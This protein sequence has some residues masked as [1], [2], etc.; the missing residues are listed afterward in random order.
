MQMFKRLFYF[1]LTN[2]LVVTTI[3]IILA[4]VTHFTGFQ[5]N[6]GG[7][8][9]LLALCFV[10]GFGG[11]FISLA[12]SKFMAKKFYGVQIIDPNTTNTMERNLITKV[13]DF[14]RRANLPKMPEVGYYESAEPNAFATGRSKSSSLVAVSTGLLSS[15]TEDEV[16]GVLAHEIAHI[17]NGDMV[18]LTLIQGVVN[19][20]AMFIS[21]IITQAIMNALRKN[22]DNGRGVGCG[23][24]LLRQMIY[25]FVSI[26]F[27]LLG[28]IV[29]NYFSRQREFRADAGSAKYSS[30]EKMT[31]ALQ[32][33]QKFA[34]IPPSRESGRDPEADGN[35]RALNAFKISARPES[36]MALLRTHP[37]LEERI[38]ALQQRTYN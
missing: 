13:Y 24:F 36:F 6:T 1:L 9:G 23:D 25:N 4:L 38:A 10:W 3:G 17:A 11:A 16:D 29:V 20:F 26:A 14:A 8:G 28:S 22:D 30:R 12:L 5:F 32:R 37:P 2:I 21:W 19:S 34:A 18:T 27:M 7:M 35:A 33:L 15:M 31:A